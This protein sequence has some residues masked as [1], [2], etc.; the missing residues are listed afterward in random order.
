MDTDAIPAALE[1]WA[2][3]STCLARVP[4]R[5]TPGP[6][7]GSWAAVPVPALA[8]DDAEGFRFLLDLS[9]YVLVRLPD[10]STPEVEVGHDGDVN[11]LRLQPPT[12]S[13]PTR[14]VE[15]TFR[16]PEK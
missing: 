14:T 2:N 6:A 16:I 5:I 7:E 13:E 1:W 11:R 12:G 8:G 3:S 4:V 10:D 15:A 9:P